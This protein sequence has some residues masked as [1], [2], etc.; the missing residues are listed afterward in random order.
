MEGMG[1]VGQSILCLL[2]FESTKEV[3]SLYGAWHSTNTLPNMVHGQ[4]FH[5]ITWQ[6]HLRATLCQPHDDALSSY[7]GLS[8]GNQSN[9]QLYDLE[10][11]LLFQEMMVMSALF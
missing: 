11:K 4:A 8:P 1:Q 9:F 7:L 6:P 3:F 10:N 2:F 5:M